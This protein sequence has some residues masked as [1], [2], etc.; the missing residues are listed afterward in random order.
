MRLKMQLESLAEEMYKSRSHTAM[1]IKKLAGT[2]FTE[3]I[4][5]DAVP[6]IQARL[7]MAANL[8]RRGGLIQFYDEQTANA[9][10]AYG[11]KS[12][13]NSYHSGE[14]RPTEHLIHMWRVSSRIG[15][16]GKGQIIVENDKVVPG[17]DRDWFL[18]DLLWNGTSAYVVPMELTKEEEKRLARGEQ[19]GLLAQHKEA[20][21]MRNIELSRR[22]IQRRYNNSLQVVP[23]RR[24][25]GKSYDYQKGM[26]PQA[27]K[28]SRDLLNKY[29][30]GDT[31]KGG[32]SPGVL[33]IT[34][35]KKSWYYP[36]GE[37]KRVS[38][39]SWR[40]ESEINRMAGATDKNLEMRYASTD[41]VPVEKKN[42]SMHYGKVFHRWFVAKAK[43]GPA[44]YKDEF[45]SDAPKKMSFYNRFRGRFY[46]NQI[47]RAGI[48][49]NVVD[50]FHEY[51][52]DCVYRG[53]ISAALT[54]EQRTSAKETM[55]ALE[56][57]AEL[58][59]Q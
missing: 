57:E 18:F 16:D 14:N 33:G 26:S 12:W 6:I 24:S 48:G 29:G 28:R 17:K 42:I 53:L 3:R 5:Q 27:L 19:Y 56:K 39:E 22:D 37:K 38:L 58:F 15:R 41:F 11:K 50:D 59:F 40:K 45:E 8:P 1:D 20:M 4:L 2:K 36:V 32:Q 9:K 49:A 51:V 30:S 34:H 54:D 7:K 46:F 23:A 25:V 52:I 10:R 47:A 13:A 31:V 44:D 55:E 43:G 35:K 21:R